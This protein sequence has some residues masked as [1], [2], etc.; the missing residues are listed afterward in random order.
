M[1]PVAGF[2]FIAV[3]LQ[4]NYATR[5]CQKDGFWF[6]WSNYTQCYDEGLTQQ[7]CEIPKVNQT[8]LVEVNCGRR[9]NFRIAGIITSY[10]STTSLRLK[11][12]QKLDIVFRFV[13]F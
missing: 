4:M 5:I 12:S 9:D 11:L 8:K 1:I 7:P 10:F 2:Q 6:N 13:R 3:T